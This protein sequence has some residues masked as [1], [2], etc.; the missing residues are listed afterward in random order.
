[1]KHHEIDPIKPDLIHHLSPL[2]QYL[3]QRIKINLQRAMPI[4]LTFRV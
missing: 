2:L 1:M 4:Q 3:S